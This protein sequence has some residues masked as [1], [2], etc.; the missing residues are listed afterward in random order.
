MP[1]GR[2]SH[3]AHVIS[4]KL[5]VWGGYFKS[6]PKV[7]WDPIKERLLS[8]VQIFHLQEGRWQTAMTR[9][10]RPLGVRGHASAVLDDCILYFG[11]YCGHDDCFH[12]SLK[13]MNV[14]EL[15]WT[16][17][18]PQNVEDCP[19]EKEDSCMVP[20][21]FDDKKYLL[22]VGGYGPSSTTNHSQAKN[23][24]KGFLT[25]HYRT[26]EQHY[27]NIASGNTSIFFILTVITKF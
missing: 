11:G 24:S 3:S 15:V 5:Y 18:V 7:H 23:T 27:F 14:N 1:E 25:K 21:T 19:M 6:L 8:E 2:R 10:I 20:L 22:I 4:D 16:D 13:I 12:N 9:G 17:L 26:N